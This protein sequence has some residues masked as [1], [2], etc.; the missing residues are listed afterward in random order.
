MFFYQI[1]LGGYPEF[2]YSEKEATDAM[3]KFATKLIMRDIDKEIRKRN[4]DLDVEY[5]Y[6]CPTHIANSITI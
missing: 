2:L 3:K 1:F 5:C 6:L 4:K